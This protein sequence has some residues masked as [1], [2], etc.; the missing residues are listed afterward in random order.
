LVHICPAGDVAT[1]L[2]TWENLFFIAH[3]KDFG[4]KGLHVTNWNA[5]A[6]PWQVEQSFAHAIWDDNCAGP[7]AAPGADRIVGCTGTTTFYLSRVRP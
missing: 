3:N 1:T 2:N 4:A 5:V 6:P 7:S